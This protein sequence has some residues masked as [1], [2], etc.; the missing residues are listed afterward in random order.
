VK[1]QAQIDLEAEVLAKEGPDTVV[2]KGAF[3][4]GKRTV[5][6]YWGEPGDPNRRIIGEAVVDLDTGLMEGTIDEQP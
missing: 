2:V 3:G 4:T 1:F 5:P 6:L